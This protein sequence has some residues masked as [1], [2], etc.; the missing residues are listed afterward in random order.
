M[1]QEAHRRI[2]NG[3]ATSL[4]QF[5]HCHVL[6]VV[7]SNYCKLSAHPGVQ[8]RQLYPS[9][10]TWLSTAQVIRPFS[11]PLDH[12]PTYSK[13]TGRAVF[14]KDLC[15][16][17]SPNVMV[18]LFTGFLLCYL[19]I[20]IHSFDLYKCTYILI[21]LKCRCLIVQCFLYAKTNLRSL[22]WRHVSVMITTNTSSLVMWMMCWDILKT[23]YIF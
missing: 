15:S 1:P 19:S 9:P 4:P 12:T 14:M 3:Q 7:S 20:H 21:V 16:L 5:P 10:G 2:W 13:P 6:S 23:R 11:W 17:T 18:V 8:W 22:F